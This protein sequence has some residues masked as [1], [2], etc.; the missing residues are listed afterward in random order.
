MSQ[1][2]KD[3]SE[4]AGRGITGSVDGSKVVVG[5]TRPMA[6]QLA[7]GEADPCLQ[8]ARVGGCRL[9]HCVVDCSSQ[10]PCCIA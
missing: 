1:L 5:S 2:V 10:C 6:E 8:A 4:V 3:A 7:L 9:Q